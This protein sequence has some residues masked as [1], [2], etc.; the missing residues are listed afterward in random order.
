MLY[1]VDYEIK[2][3]PPDAAAAEALCANSEVCRMVK[4]VVKALPTQV[5]STSKRE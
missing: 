5:L 2:A 3:R 4:D 1:C